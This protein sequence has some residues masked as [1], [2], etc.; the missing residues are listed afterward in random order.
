MDQQNMTLESLAA[1]ISQLTETLTSGLRA[2]NFPE[3]SFAADAPPQLPPSPAIQGPR[4]QLVE[5]LMN[6]L[7]LAVGPTEYFLQLGF[8]VRSFSSACWI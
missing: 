2:A 4:L 1:A 6:M 5:A 7:H 3:P 8:G